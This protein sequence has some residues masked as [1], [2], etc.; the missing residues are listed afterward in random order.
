MN[1]KML[2]ITIASAVFMLFLLVFLGD[3]A[4]STALSDTL[5]YV[6]FIPSLLQF[7]YSPGHLLGLGFLVLLLA[8]VIFGRFYCSFLCPLGILQDIFIR[9]S[10]N[11]RK[12]HT[13]QQSYLPVTYGLLVLTVVTATL[14]SFALINLRHIFA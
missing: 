6:Q 9:I 7:I 2:R 13:F 4:I 1:L 10:R 5:L 3:E 11:F 8:S 14:G 12:R